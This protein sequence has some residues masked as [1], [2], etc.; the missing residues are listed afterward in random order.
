MTKDREGN[1]LVS[2]NSV[3]SRWKE[4]FV[5]L[6]NEENEREMKTD[7]VQR[8][9]QEAQRINKGEVRSALKRIKSAKAVCREDKPL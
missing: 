5:K 4:S 1:V 8:V 7:G 3:L 2:E 6:M 9:D